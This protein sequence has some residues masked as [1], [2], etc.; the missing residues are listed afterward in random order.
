MRLTFSLVLEL[1]N[2]REGAAEF[3]ETRLGQGVVVVNQTK[4]I[5]DT[6]DRVLLGHLLSDL[7]E[8]LG[9]VEDAIWWHILR[10]VDEGKERKGTYRLRQFLRSICSSCLYQWGKPVRAAQELPPCQH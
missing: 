7:H 3:G 10:K 1:I 2:D 5:V 6:K 9:R 8:P 4:T